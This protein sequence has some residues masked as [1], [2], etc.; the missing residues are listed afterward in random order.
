MIGLTRAA[1]TDVLVHSTLLNPASLDLR[2]S[3]RYCNTFVHIDCPAVLPA[4]A[5]IPMLYLLG[6]SLKGTF[7]PVS[8]SETTILCMTKEVTGMTNYVQLS[9]PILAIT[10]GVLVAWQAF[11]WWFK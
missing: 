7:K 2:G 5:C 8:D 3:H 4:N 10:F 9:I 1:H 11:F 6:V